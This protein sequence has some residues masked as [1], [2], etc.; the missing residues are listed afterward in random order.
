MVASAIDQLQ[1]ILS[2]VFLSKVANNRDHL[3]PYVMLSVFYFI[4]YDGKGKYS[5][6]Q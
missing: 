1:A 4:V 2:A 5:S 3:V 6:S